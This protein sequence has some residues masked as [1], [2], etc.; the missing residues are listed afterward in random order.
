[1]HLPESSLLQGFATKSLYEQAL[2]EHG[3][4]VESGLTILHSCRSA[5]VGKQVEA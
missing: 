5:T 1:M 3:R 2:Y 4:V